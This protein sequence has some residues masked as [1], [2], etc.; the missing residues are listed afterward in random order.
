MSSLNQPFHSYTFDPQYT[1][2]SCC[3]TRFFKDAIPSI[4]PAIEPVAE[5]P[6]LINV[7]KKIK[8]GIFFPGSNVVL[9]KSQKNVESYSVCTDNDF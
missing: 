4:E 7:K 1:M 6:I 2:G 8:T 5:L 3:H 9:V